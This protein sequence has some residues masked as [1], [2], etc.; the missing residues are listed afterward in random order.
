MQTLF[1]ALRDFFGSVNHQK[2]LTLVAQ[3]V[4]DG[5]ALR[6]IQT[7]L[8]AGSYGQGQLF[9]AERGTHKVQ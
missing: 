2:L 3:R 4:A 8:K 9:P 1:F 7:M 6:L 5:R